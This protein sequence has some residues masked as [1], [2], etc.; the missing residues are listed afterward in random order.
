MFDADNRDRDR[1]AGPPS[2][3]SASTQDDSL[4]NDAASRHRTAR[5][6]RARTESPFLAALAETNRR[7][8]AEPVA[9]AGLEADKAKPDGFAGI[10]EHGFRTNP[11][12]RALPAVERTQPDADRPIPDTGLPA[13]HGTSVSGDEIWRPLIDPM[14]VI[15]GIVDAKLLI[16]STTVLGALLGVAVALSTPKKYEA[17]TEILVDPRELQ[18]V[19]RDLMQG[20]L[21][22]DATLALVENQAR[23]L[24]SGTVLNKV[25]DRLNLSQDPEFNG[26]KGG[27]IGSIVSDL[28]SLLSRNDG[29]GGDRRHALAVQ[30]LARSLSVERGGKTFVIV[31]SVRTE[32]AEKSALIANTMTEVFLQTYGELQSG[33]AGRAADELNARLDQLRD[34]VEAAERKVETFKAENDLVD[35]QGRLITDDE[36][37]RLNEQLTTARART[38]ELKAKA[39]SSKGVGVEEAIGGTLPEE[40][41]SHIITELRSQ[42][43]AAKQQADRLSVQLGPRHPQL[44]AV[45]A[46]LS[47]TREQIAGEMR[48]IVASI[49]TELKRAVELEQQLS[50]RLAQLKVRQG[51]VSDDL[52]SLRE[53][54]RDAAAKRSVY[55]GFLLRAT[56]TGEQKDINTANMSV[57]SHAFAPLTPLGPSRSMIALTG[58]FLGF[59]AGIGIGGMHG[60]WQSLRENTGGRPRRTSRMPGSSDTLPPGPPAPTDPARRASRT[61]PSVGDIPVHGRE[62]WA[63]PASQREGAVG[64][65][66]GGS[67]TDP[68]MRRNRLAEWEDFA[69]SYVYDAPALHSKPGYQWPP[70]GSTALPVASSRDASTHLRLDETDMPRTASSIEE[71]RHRLR[72]FN[73]AVRDFA[74]RRSRRRSA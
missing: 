49:Q 64:S 3:L 6:G 8:D 57:I 22:S 32:E 40:L 46:Q 9:S 69:P 19:G 60:A 44:L 74:E 18:L 56:E 30:N 5:I 26:E 62:S 11:K 10:Q 1:R 12:D 23:I 71:I 70:I 48:R 45:Q 43:A 65:G 51:S 16:V 38:L 52:V 34:G 24:S 63:N 29:S 66:S 21:P 31:V 35:A 13:D 39:A 58:A 36:I 17:A 2:S 54:E 28:R 67:Q 72:E 4:S 50:S 25:V 27:G 41:S 47:G 68:A 59:L 15:K 14:K 53:L 55:E 20:G 7:R 37:V 73:D 61:S 33:T 42:Y